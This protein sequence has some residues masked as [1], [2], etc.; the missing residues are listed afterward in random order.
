MISSTVFSVGVGVE[1]GE[2]LLNQA[3]TPTVS[4]EGRYIFRGQPQHQ[5]D[6]KFSVVVGVGVLTTP[7]PAFN[8][9]L[10][11]THCIHRTWLAI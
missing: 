2:R 7:T 6:F 9:E 10:E 3:P 4:L 1:S 11:I 8:T 5:H